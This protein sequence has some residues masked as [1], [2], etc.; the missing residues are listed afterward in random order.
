M[1]QRAW[2]LF[3]ASFQGRLEACATLHLF[4]G[5][6]HVRDVDLVGGHL[7]PQ[8]WVPMRSVTL[9]YC[10]TKV[11]HPQRVLSRKKECACWWL[12]G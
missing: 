6:A 4:L 10:S 8:I 12:V 7:G 11:F 3:D 5:P 1:R 2:G 9:L